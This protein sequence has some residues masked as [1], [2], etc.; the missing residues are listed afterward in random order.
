MPELLGLPETLDTLQPTD[1]P[2][3]LPYLPDLP[4]LW[5][6]PEWPKAD[7]PASPPPAPDNLPEQR[8]ETGVAH[9]ADRHP[10]LKTGALGL[11]T[12]LWVARRR[13]RR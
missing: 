9:A 2:S 4:E 1:A 12:L 7:S 13:R 3:P 5:E 10:A 6:P 8:P 11:A